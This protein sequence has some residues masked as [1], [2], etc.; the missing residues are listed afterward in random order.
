M[1]CPGKNY[2][3]YLDEICGWKCVKLC[4]NG[5]LGLVVWL[6]YSRLDDL[7]VFIFSLLLDY[8]FGV[9][10]HWE[11]LP[12]LSYSHYIGGIKMDGKQYLQVTRWESIEAFLLSVRVRVTMRVWHLFG[13]K[14]KSK[15]RS[16]WHKFLSI[17]H[18]EIKFSSIIL[19]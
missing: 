11:H 19:W 5:S 17:L 15:F 13:R 4:G 2:E 12:L 10:W 7:K 1:E 18:R 14:W 3:T 16:G 8:C 9:F 6:I